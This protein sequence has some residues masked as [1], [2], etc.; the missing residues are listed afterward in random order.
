MGSQEAYI[1][2]IG[3]KQ[4][5][6]IRYVYLKKQH[7]TLSLHCQANICLLQANTIVNTLTEPEL[8]MQE[9]EAAD[10]YGPC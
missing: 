2:N 1:V 5:I 3:G 4:Y 9:T 8:N 6:Y 10:Y 7:H